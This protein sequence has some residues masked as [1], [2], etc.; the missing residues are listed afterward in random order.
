RCAVVRFFS[1][2]ALE[3]RGMSVEIPRRSFPPTS[4]VQG[5]PTHRA[6]E[7]LPQSQAAPCDS[8]DTHPGRCRIQ[9]HVDPLRPEF[10]PQSCLAFQWSDT[11]YI[12]S[13]RVDT[14]QSERP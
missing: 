3:I 14:A 9:R 11:K 5:S 12:C 6:A 8:M 1:R 10:L 4:R 13:S 7:I 2:A